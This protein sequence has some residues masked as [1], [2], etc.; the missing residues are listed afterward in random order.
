[1]PVS[2]PR[3]GRAGVGD[4]PVGEIAIVSQ[5]TRALQSP[6][7]LFGQER[8]GDLL[9]SISDLL[10]FRLGKTGKRAADPAVV[11]PTGLPPGFGD[12]LIL[13]NRVSRAAEV[14]RKST[15]LNSSH[16]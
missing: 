7:D 6:H 13:V 16:G 8:P 9:Q 1:M 4:R 15:R 2:H 14:D 5:P 11:S 12:R 3:I 10:S